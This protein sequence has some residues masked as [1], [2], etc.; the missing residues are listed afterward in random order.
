MQRS[1]ES[2]PFTLTPNTI[3]KAIFTVNRHAKTATNNK[4]LYKLKQEALVKLIKEG[5]AQKIGLHFSNNP[6]YSRQQSDVLVECNEFT[7]HIPPSKEDF[8]TLPHL[9]ELNSSIRNPKV[10]MSL[11][12]AKKV[13]QSYTGI[14]E[15]TAAA[16]HKASKGYQKPVFKRLGE[17]Y[18]PVWRK[19]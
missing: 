9:G 11:N 3:A 1:T 16:S 6:K 17:S 10:H 19:K 8:Q 13:L 4:Y 7:F 5:K 14:K 12:T 15:N 2:K 18:G